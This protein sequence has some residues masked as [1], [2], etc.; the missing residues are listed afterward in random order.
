MNIK[1]G[2]L[3]IA[4]VIRVAGV[5]LAFVLFV[6]LTRSDSFFAGISVAVILS[7]LSYGIAWIIEGFAQ[8]K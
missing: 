4:R 5:I 2:L 8:D 1:E 6:T 7:V 3:R